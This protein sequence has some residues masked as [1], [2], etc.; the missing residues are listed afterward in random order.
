LFQ[1]IIIDS[2]LGF[3]IRNNTQYSGTNIVGAQGEPVPTSNLELCCT[4]CRRTNN[5]VA[6]GFQ[7]STKTC[8]TKRILGAPTTVAGIVSGFL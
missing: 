4:L 6:F 2:C 1:L 8:W 5:C 7:P 3:S